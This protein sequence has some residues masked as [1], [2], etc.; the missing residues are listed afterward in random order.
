[1]PSCCRT[2]TA[3]K[4]QVTIYDK[5]RKGY[6][7]DLRRIGDHIR[8]K[9]LDAGLTLDQVAVLL[10]VSRSLIHGWEKHRR[11]PV[12]EIRKRLI[13]FLGYDPNDDSGDDAA[14]TRDLQHA[15]THS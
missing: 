5:E 14:G 4:S 13:A 6:P 9:R 2:L 1:L 12:G 15:D 11:W 7:K 8:R 3:A 10:G